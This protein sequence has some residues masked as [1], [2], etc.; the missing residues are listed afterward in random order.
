MN[1]P[2]V[3]AGV[4][5]LADS[6]LGLYFAYTEPFSSTYAALTGYLFWLS[7][8]LLLVSLLC[9]YGVHYAFLAAAVLAVAVALDAPFA[10][11]YRFGPQWVLVALSLVVLVAS[12]VA[13]RKRSSLSEQ[14]N[15]MNLPVF[16]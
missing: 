7:V 14:V 3:I 4:L 8:V 6:V 2:K 10:L 12:V 9:I 5:A 15:P 16:G 11:T 1:A 13:F